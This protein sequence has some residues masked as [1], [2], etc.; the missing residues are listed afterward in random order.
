MPTKFSLL[1]LSSILSSLYCFAQPDGNFKEWGGVTSE[2]M[3][4]RECS[5]E[6][7]ADALL[8]L[9]LADVYYNRKG[10]FYSTGK[11][12]ITTAYYQRYKV[13]TERGTE[14]ANFKFKF[15]SGADQEIKEIKG[16]AYNLDAEGKIQKTELTATD[17]HFNRLNDYETEVA[18]T[19]PGVKK[20]SVFELGYHRDQTVN[21]T[22]PSWYFHSDVPS[23]RST[24]RI[25]FLD[26]IEYFVARHI[27]NKDIEEK[28]EPFVSQI[29]VP[30]PAY[31]ETERLKGHMV[32]FTTHNL[33]AVHP[34]PYMN[35]R[36]NYMDHV[37]FQLMSFHFPLNQSARIISTWYRFNSHFLEDPNFGG[38]INQG[39]IPKRL[40]ENAIKAEASNTDKPKQRAE[41]IFNFVRNSMSWDGYISTFPKESND[42]TWKIK[43]GNSAEINLLLLN[44][45]RK[46]G[47]KAYPMLVGTRNYGYLYTEYPI[48]DQFKNVVVLLEIDSD[49]LILDA[50]EK[51]LS[52]G[53]PKYELLNNY[54]YIIKDEMQGD[55]YRINDVS[56][57]RENILIEAT[58]NNG[59]LKGQITTTCDNYSQA[60][61]RRLKA[62]GRQN[63]MNE[64]LK[65]KAPNVVIE[66][67]TDSVDEKQNTVTQK[68]NYTAQPATDNDGSIYI[69]IPSLYGDYTNPFVSPERVSAVDFGFKQKIN[70]VLQMEI[71]EGYEVD[72]LWGLKQ[73]ITPDTGIVFLYGAEVQEN[74]LLMRQQL[75][76][77]KSLYQVKDYPYFYEFHQQY[78][79]LNQ[80]PVVLR[81]KT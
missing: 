17:V 65:K 21:Y 52:F 43:S 72:S 33:P 36:T 37:S 60:T 14:N 64:E 10:D 71:P 7:N 70:T 61:I 67:A 77:R 59:Q 45:L 81:K 58:L 80:Q 40:L 74:L 79:H 62:T 28:S 56:T 54:G 66:S 30:L 3:N 75:E 18:F 78:Y 12:S 27:T 8:L 57:N 39:G 16:A 20:G 53:V 44:A 1:F 49:R 69:T 23:V 25:G 55:W 34:E 9:D 24:L 38:N 6:K 35:S 11:F 48:L 50:T 63:V 41:A 47:F 4:I 2:E 13:F 5:F 19:I 29:S 76:Y 42:R 46:T 51:F 22:L 31:G 26:A 73:V 68:I 32:T 15:R